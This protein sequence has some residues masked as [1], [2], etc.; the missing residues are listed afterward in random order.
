MITAH[1]EYIP[2]IRLALELGPNLD[3]HVGLVGE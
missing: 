1:L 3:S 2:E